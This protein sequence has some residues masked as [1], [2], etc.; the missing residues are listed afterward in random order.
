MKIKALRNYKQ[1]P[2]PLFLERAWH[3]HDCF[4]AITP[5]P[6]D[7]PSETAFKASLETL[8]SAVDL[9]LTG[10]HADVAAAKLLRKGVETKMDL[11]ADFADKDSNGDAS[12]IMNYGFEASDGTHSKVL[13]VAPTIKTVDNSAS[14]QFKLGIKAVPGAR[15]YEAEVK[16]PTGDWVTAGYSTGT[17]N[18]M[19]F[20]LV[21]G[22]LY[23]IRVRAVAG[24]SNRGP[25][26]EV[27]TKMCT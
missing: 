19:V 24:N 8:E 14:G 7:V 10:N 27:L 25:W 23:S 5:Y 1:L 17:R 15:G 9:S 3:V 22:T 16:T 20:K 4:E 26:S 6:L 12:V 11:F 18:F 2:Q 21:T 13:L